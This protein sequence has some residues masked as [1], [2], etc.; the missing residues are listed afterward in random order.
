MKSLPTTRFGKPR[1]MVRGRFTTPKGKRTIDTSKPKVRLDGTA[2][3]TCIPC[4]QRTVK[5]LLIQSA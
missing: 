1:E 4:Q 3:P 5:R 2:D